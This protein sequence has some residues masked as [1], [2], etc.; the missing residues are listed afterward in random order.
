MGLSFLLHGILFA[1]VL[2]LWIATPL[3]PG[4]GTGY[5]TMELGDFG[6]AGGGGKPSPSARNGKFPPAT[7]QS[8]T[9][10][11]S[12][13]VPLASETL[14]P[15]QGVAGVGEGSG[16][17]SGGGQG[18]D[19]GVGQGKGG[20]GDESL[21][22]YIRQVLARIERKKQYPRISQ[23]NG[24]EGI[25]TVDLHIGRSGQLLAYELREGP[26]NQRLIQAAMNSIQAAAPFP[27]LPE[28]YPRETLTLQV[29]VRYQLH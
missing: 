26:N 21:S 29:P 18:G 13:R 3:R 12:N 17:G 16:V 27:P 19:G 23:Q 24:E 15:K 7:V 6:E 8:S 5:V 4:S 2:W 20:G 10:K 1:A 28:Q 9:S 11:K 25:V 14:S 22:P